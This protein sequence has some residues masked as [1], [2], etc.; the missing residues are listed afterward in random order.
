LSIC[1]GLQAYKLGTLVSS[2]AVVCSCVQFY[3]NWG[4][5]FIHQVSGFALK[6]RH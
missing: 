6:F 2:C 4:D 3:W 1:G 5:Q